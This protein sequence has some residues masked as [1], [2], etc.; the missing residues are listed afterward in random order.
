MSQREIDELYED[1]R[2]R[3][4][5]LLERE[6]I[7]KIDADF[8]RAKA[9]YNTGNIRGGIALKDDALGRL[10]DYIGE[11]DDVQCGLNVL[12]E[13]GDAAAFVRRTRAACTGLKA[14]SAQLLT[15]LKDQWQ[16]NAWAYWR[17]LQRE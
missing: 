15:T 16:T 2:R 17:K 13:R 1:L 10:R 7:D 6:P 3:A 12:A 9:Q 11:I 4:K 8:A 14:E 5:R